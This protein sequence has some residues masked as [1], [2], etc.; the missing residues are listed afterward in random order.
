[1]SQENIIIVFQIFSKIFPLR[2]GSVFL[3][4]QSLVETI[5]LKRMGDE[6]SYWGHGNIYQS[7]RNNL[8]HIRLIELLHHQ[9]D[10][11]LNFHK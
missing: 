2:Q 6:I 10:H 9:V 5:Y 11:S 8:E 4:R 1:M 3:L 7:E